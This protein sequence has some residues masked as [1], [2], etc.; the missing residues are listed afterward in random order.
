LNVSNSCFECY[1]G[2]N[3]NLTSNCVNGISSDG[4]GHC[5]SCIQSYFGM[6]CDKSCTCEQGNCSEGILG[7]G[8]CLSCNNNYFGVNCDKPCTCIEGTCYD[9]I[10]GNGTCMCNNNYYG[11]NCNDSCTCAQGK[12]SEGFLGNGSCSC[13]NNYMGKNC[14]EICLTTNCLTSC[15]CN[16]L[17]QEQLINFIEGNITQSMLNIT[18]TVLFVY[19]NFSLSSISL[20]FD[21]SSS[22][23]VD[24]C[25]S[26]KNV[27]LTLNLKNTT[28]KTIILLK[29]TSGCFNVDGYSIK[30]INEPL[31]TTAKTELD[32][33]SL[34]VT[35]S[36]NNNCDDNKISSLPA[37]EIALIIGGS[38]IGIVIIVIVIVILVPSIRRK[39]FV[40]EDVKISKHNDK[41]N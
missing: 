26:I 7:D 22:I 13:D 12:C 23:V 27:S 38:I 32:E 24:G 20:N 15:I 34:F 11:I 39:I 3:C 21:S 28:S 37:W 6:N 25:F 18:S 4:D 17:D 10:T 30:Y 41:E 40:T 36:E 35:L 29:S 19:K 16:P 8:T 5:I 1:N 9:G 31:C 2:F 14:D 33:D